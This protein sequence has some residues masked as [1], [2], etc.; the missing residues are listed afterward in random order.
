MNSSSDRNPV[1]LSVPRDASTLRIAARA[2]AWL[3]AGAAIAVPLVA[4]QPQPSTPQTKP[5]TLASDDATTRPV[6]PSPSV[7]EVIKEKP[8]YIDR[9]I[10]KDEVLATVAGQEVRFSDIRPT[11]VSSYGLDVL[12]NV[13]QLKLAQAKAKE[14]NVSVTAADIAEETRLTIA[15]VAPDAPEADYPA[16]IAQLLQQQRLSRA[17]FDLVMEI[18]ANLRKIAISMASTDV[19]ESTLLQAFNDRYG[20]TIRIRHIALTNLQDVAEAQKRIQAGVPFDAVAREMSQNRRTAPLGGELP[21][22]SKATVDLK[23]NFKEAAFA[24]KEG[25]VSDP[26]QAEGFYHLI[27]LEKRIP[28]KAVKFEDYRE[29]IRNDLRN[30]ALDYAVRQFR[31]TLA[32]QARESLKITEPT[33]NEQYQLRIQA[34]EKAQQPPR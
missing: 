5:T 10:E 19:A 22:F 31:S 25:E 6:T 15:Q 2:C 8:V 1:V 9:F 26:V 32:A 28:P 13:V 11:L 23:E 16:I 3:A 7:V 29:S 24:L 18:N 33:L 14:R 27:K 30:R 20:E 17:D 4:C 12:L 34:A 21:P